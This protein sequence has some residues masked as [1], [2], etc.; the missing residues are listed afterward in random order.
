MAKISI[1][2]PIYNVSKYLDECLRSVKNQTLRDIEVICIDD[3]ST[4]NSLDIVKSYVAEDSRFK[5]ITKPNAGY[6]D[7]MNR[8]FDAAEGKYIGIV[9]SDDYIAPNMF[10]TLYNVAELNNCE[11]VKSDYFEFNSNQ[12]KNQ[13]YIN[14]VSKSEYYG[15][16]VSY[17]TCPSLFHF[18]MN[19]WTG[20]YLNNFIR[21]N[22]IKHNVTP[23]AAYQD[24]GFWFQTLSLAKKIVF[25]NQ[26]FYHYRQDNPNSSINS[27]SKVY[28]MCDE[29]AYIED[30]LKN[31]PDL[32]ADLRG[33]FLA[34]KYYNYMYTYG[35]IA[36]EYKIPF[37]ERFGEEFKEPIKNG[38][39]TD[40]HL[41]K[42]VL[43]MINR[44]I[45]DPVQ[46]YYSDTIWGIQHQ[47]IDFEL[48][49]NNI[50]S[51]R[52]VHILRKVRL[53]P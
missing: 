9:E 31:H 13:T 41:P 33:I 29:Y 8:G 7:S 46:F 10:E 4:D 3:G 24:N 25:V 21:S 40:K 36:N 34:R 5:F 14:T 17:Q 19:T 16:V 50:R 12:K 42:N 52:W 44:I 37:L 20:I 47:T 43:N 6:G 51:N 23:G 53:F 1:V 26:A 45:S 48:K 49:L 2:V 39:L 27:K 15:K 38:Q 11:V 32:D 28:C 30:F 35:R 22:K 18:R